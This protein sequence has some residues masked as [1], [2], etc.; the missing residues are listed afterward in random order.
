MN[1]KCQDAFS[2]ANQELL[3]EQ[4]LCL[5]FVVLYCFIGPDQSEAQLL[6][7]DSKVLGTAGL[8]V[9]NSSR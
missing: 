9:E 6:G 1:I 7:P 3:K 5:I 8:Y 2:F 4:G